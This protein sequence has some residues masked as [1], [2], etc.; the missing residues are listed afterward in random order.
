MQ[1]HGVKFI[2]TWRG[3]DV[4]EV[5]LAPN[6]FGA[7]E[8]VLIVRQEAEAIGLEFREHRKRGIAMLRNWLDK[9]IEHNRLSATVH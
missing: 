6:R 4:L 7:D 5:S 1:Y 2:E 3:P 9:Y 8:G